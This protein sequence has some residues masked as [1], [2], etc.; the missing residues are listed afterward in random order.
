MTIKIHKRK[1]LKV[2]VRITIFVVLCISS[3]FAVYLIYY[4]FSSNK[5][6]NNLFKYDITNNADY[7][8]Y[9]NDG[10]VKGND[11][12]VVSNDINN[13]DIRYNYN[14]K[15]DTDSEVDYSYNIIGT[16]IIEYQNVEYGKQTL[17]SKDYILLEEKNGNFKSTS[18]FSLSDKIQLDYQKYAEMIKDYITQKGINVTGRIELK[19]N[20]DTN[21]TLEN[22][23]TYSYNDV[24]KV[25]VPLSE[26]V[27]MLTTDYK[28]NDSGIVKSDINN[29]KLELLPITI[30]SVTL[31][32]SLVLLIY[33]SKKIIFINIKSEYRK[34][35]DKIFKEYSEI[36]V[37]VSSSIEYEDYTF[38]DIKEFEDMIDLEEEYKSPILYYEKISG[39][40]SWFVIIKDNFMY[41][42]ILKA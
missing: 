8:I 41:R 20:I 17:D 15:G 28:K 26:K 3:L 24:I 2:W 27:I 18:S 21:G 7:K 34:Q 36:L 9:L 39:Y 1:V 32:T 22:G 12:P 29:N 40:E 11:Q 25:N 37:E 4:G 33:L 16:L 19:M 6:S 31:L 30:G 10:S 42:Y 5:N 23:K 38:I 14:F 35:I 13:I